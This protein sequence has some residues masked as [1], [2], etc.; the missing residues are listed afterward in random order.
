[1]AETDG[2]LERVDGAAVEA[3]FGIVCTLKG[4]QVIDRQDH[5]VS[6]ALEAVGLSE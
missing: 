3:R 4:G 2:L 6:E 5:W 1:L